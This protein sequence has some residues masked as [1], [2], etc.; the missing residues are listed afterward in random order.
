MGLTDGCEGT[1]ES[2]QEQKQQ[3]WSETEH[4]VGAQGWS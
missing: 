1:G 2:E 4:F 3:F